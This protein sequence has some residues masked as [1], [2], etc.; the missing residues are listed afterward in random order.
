MMSSSKRPAADF[1]LA[2]DDLHSIAVMCAGV[3]W[4]A[5]VDGPVRAKNVAQLV[6]Q[7]L[8]EHGVDTVFGLMGSGNL[9]FTN[10]LVA[11]GA[12]YYAARHEGAAVS[13][14]DGWA[15]VTGR[16][17]ICSIHQGPGLTNTLTALGEAAKARTPMLVLSADTAASTLRSNFRIDQH[18]LVES[19]GAIADRVHSPATAADDAARGLRRAELERRPV[20][21][22]LPID[23]QAEAVPDGAAAVPPTVPLPA[24][25]APPAT[26]IAAAVELLRAARRPAIVAGRGAV[27]ADARAPIEALGE[28]LG[29]ILATSAPAKGFFA[30]N[31]YAVGISGGFASA[32]AT[33]L[34]AEA[35]AVL[36]FGAGLNHW[37]TRHGKLIADDATVIQV[38]LESDALGAHREIALGVIGDAA[39]AAAALGAELERQG[40][41]IDGFR[42]EATA[43]KIAAGDWHDEPYEDEGTAEWID[44]RTLSIAVDEIIPA[45]RSVAVDSGAFLGYPSMFFAV[46]DARS[47]V[48]PNAFQAVGLG[49][50]C[51]IGAAVAR[52][53]RVT[54]AAL[55][56]GGTFMALAELE[57]AARLGLRL[58]VIVYD[59]AA[60]GAEVHHFRE[61]G[62]EVA[63]AQFPPA[64]IAAI[65]TAAG[66]Q[67][68]T[69]RSRAELAPLAAWVESGD[70]P[71]V[72]DAKVNPDV[73]AEWLP[74]AFRAD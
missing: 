25:P 23:T 22:M 56:D 1:P 9:V 49:L 47:W 44:P 7:T 42:D 12:R 19:V 24:A 4:G 37:T 16:V 2:E 45:E 61:V 58:A 53:E 6:G 3:D 51:A 38:D 13:M 30:G 66:C 73:C 74:D 64:D 15:R 43:A 33:E 17:A 50:G 65:A 52:P 29:A 14:A 57:T 41:A 21:L 8:A 46:P 10:A 59:D 68:V 60:Y 67:G 54:V 48:F 34:L 18:D 26:A 39:L 40:I 62:E 32:Q 31:P 55:G 70:G 28:R 72:I 5:I 63:L 11:S 36:S 20:V 35:D 71:I 27:L 69:V